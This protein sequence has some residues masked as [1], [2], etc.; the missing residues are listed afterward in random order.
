[1]DA[2][3]DLPWKVNQSGR[4]WLSLRGELVVV[5]KSPDG[6]SIRFAPETPALLGSLTDGERAE[7]SEDGTVQLRLDGID[8]PETHYGNLAQPLGDAARDELLAWCGFTGVRW[9]GDQ[10]VAATPER[11]P[12]AV[13]SRLV[14]V[15]GRPV[16]LLLVGDGLPADGVAVPAASGSAGRRTWR[17]R[18]RAPRTA[19]STRR[20]RRRCARRCSRPRARP[21]RGARRVGARRERRLRAALAGLDRPRGR[22]DPAQAVPALLGLPALAQRRQTLPEWLRAQGRA[23]PAGRRRDRRRRD[24]ADLSD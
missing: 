22:V 10:V 9:S 24:A 2:D 3:R 14:D 6:D 7:P 8:T 13:L 23:R 4:D 18:R 19:P 17:W 20:P 5:G 16:V 21:A 11:I 15:N 12:A 1:M